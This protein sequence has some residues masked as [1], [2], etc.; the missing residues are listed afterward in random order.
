[1]KYISIL[2]AWLL[3]LSCVWGQNPDHLDHCTAVVEQARGLADQLR[4]PNIVGGVTQ[5]SAGTPA[6]TYVGVQNSIANDRKASATVKAAWE[7]CDLYNQTEDATLRITYALPALQ[8]DSL[9]HRTEII[10]AMES[11]LSLLAADAQS[12]ANVQDL[13]RITL[14]SIQTAKT[15]MDMDR[16]ATQQSAA[17]IYVPENLAYLPLRTILT[18]K[19]MAEIASQKASAKL[20]RAGNWDIQLESGVRHQ[21]MPSTPSNSALPSSSSSNGMYGGITFS[22]GTTSKLVDSHLNK[23]VDAYG[24]WK[25]NQEGDVIRNA[26]ALQQQLID[27]IATLRTSNLALGNQ[28]QVIDSNLDSIKGSDTPAGLAFSYQLRTDRLMLRIE[29][30]DTQ[31][32]LALLQKYLDDNF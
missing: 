15:R 9:N 6:Q 27:T 7:T 18:N 21:L 14:Y 20:L 13:S 10:G 29:I 25:E 31:Y 12:R 16:A 3:A 1:M 17:Q 2:F 30:E 26:A 22:W 5:P 28:M 32:R 19:Q 23:S 24:K 4:G 8:K 11:Q